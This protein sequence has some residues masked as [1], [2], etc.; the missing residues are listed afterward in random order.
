MRVDNATTKK[1]LRRGDLVS[2]LFVVEPHAAAAAELGEGVLLQL[3]LLGDKQ[4]HWQHKQE[5]QQL[6][7]LDVVLLFLEVIFR[8]GR[9]Y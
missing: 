6:L 7:V 2:L 1:I 8:K 4:Q 9:K 5:V 3:L